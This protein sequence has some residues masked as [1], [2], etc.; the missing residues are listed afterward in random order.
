MDRAR[1]DVN[2]RMK[3]ALPM[4]LLTILMVSLGCTPADPQG[5]SGIDANL[6]RRH[7]LLAERL[8]DDFDSTETL[9]ADQ[10]VN[11]SP[12]ALARALQRLDEQLSGTVA[13]ATELDGRSLP[14][15]GYAIGEGLRETRLYVSEAQRLLRGAQTRL[16]S[17]DNAGEIQTLLERAKDAIRNAGVYHDSL[18]GFVT[19][20]SLRFERFSLGWPRVELE[21]DRSAAVACMRSML[22]AESG[23]SWVASWEVET[24]ACEDLVR[25]SRTAV[26][27]M[28]SDWTAPVDAGKAES[29]Y[30]AVDE[31]LDQLRSELLRTAPDAAL[32][33]REA[34]A[35]LGELLAIP[36]AQGAM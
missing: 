23:N 1:K 15:D 25:R 36:S 32:T 30:E 12:E 26:D 21:I 27:V 22:D 31:H 19:D 8:L 5:N 17:S 33:R 35:V 34:E 28:A 7:R 20:P 6:L 2:P 13:L 14:G 11:P 18:V 9:R 24:A 10:A 4:L 16:S 3:P 29:A